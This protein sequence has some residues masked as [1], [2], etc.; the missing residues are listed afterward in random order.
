[1]TLVAYSRA[2]LRNSESTAAGG[3]SRAAP[4]QVHVAASQQDMLVGWCDIDAPAL[5]QLPVLDMAGRQRA[6]PAQDVREGAGPGRWHVEDHE[7]GRREVGGQR[8]GQFG[9]RFHPAGRGAD[10]HD[11]MVGHGGGLLDAGELDGADCGRHPPCRPVGPGPCCGHHARF[12]ASPSTV[13]APGVP[14]AP[15]AGG[16]SR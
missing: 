2:A 8:G 10:D 6:V 16:M 12:G 4:G 13:S 1:M 15:T 14:G 5:D 9:E 7:H 11:V 3:R